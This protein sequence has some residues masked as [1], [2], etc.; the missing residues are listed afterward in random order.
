MSTAPVTG[1]EGFCTLATLLELPGVILSLTLN[2][3]LFEAL[4]RSLLGLRFVLFFME[5]DI[6]SIFVKQ[7]SHSYWKSFRGAR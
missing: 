2:A 6:E 4:E 5:T 7:R 1:S 3:V